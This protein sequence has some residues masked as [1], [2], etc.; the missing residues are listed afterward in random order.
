M[1]VY[2]V[3]SNG[4]NNAT[5][6]SDQPFRTIGQALNADLNPGDEIVVRAGTYNEALNIDQGGSA[7]GDITI[8]AEEPGTA[9]IRPP[10]GSWN[11]I[12]VNAN[13]VTIEGFDIA[14]AAGDGIEAN[15][16]HHITISDNIVH[17]NGESGIQFN[18]SEFI[19]VEGNETYDNAS[20]GW[21]SGISI[22]QNRN[23]SGD[24]T[25]PGY[26][27]IIRDN[28][29]HDNVTQSGAHT[30]GNGIIIDDFQSTQTDGY[31]NYTYPTLVE[32][33]IAYGNGGKGIQVTWSDYV[34]VSNN[35]AYHN[36]VDQQN[37][38]TWRGEISNA[39]SSNN[40]FINNIAV[41]D[42]SINSHNTAIDNNSY[43]GYT[44]DNVVWQDNVLYNGTDGKLSVS[45]DGGNA[46]PS[47]ADGNLIGVDPEFVD[48]EN[49]DFTIAAGSAAMD[50]GADADGASPL[51]TPPA[52]STPDPVVTPDPAPA[53]PATDNAAPIAQDDY[54]FQAA[55]SE[56]LILEKS[57]LLSNDRDADG[58]VLV[59]T[60][61][62]DSSKGTA[63]MTDQND[64]AFTPATSATGTASVTYTVSDQHGGSDTA[65]AYIDIAAQQPASRPATGTDTAS[66]DELHTVWSDSD[67]PD[68]A[69]ENDHNSVEL[70]MRF[71]VTS[72]GEIEGARVYRG[73]AN[74]SD[75]PATLW[76]GDG[77]KIA[78][79]TFS[80]TGHA[81]WQQ[82]DFDSPV[83]V[84]AGESYVISYHAP[85]G[86][87]AVSENYFDE[88]AAHGPI[89]T[90]A[91]AGV[92]AYG[93]QS[94]LPT[95]SYHESNYWVDVVFSDDDA[96]AAPATATPDPVVDS[97]PDPV[98]DPVAD[99]EVVAAP[100]APVDA[101]A[102]AD[103]STPAD[104][105]LHTVWS[106]S[107]TPDVSAENDHNSVELGMR[108]TVT[109][110]GEIEG[111]R[112][113]RG[114]A[115]DSDMP[116]TLWDGD[117]NK[118]AT[119]TFS[120][121]GHAGWQQID[122]DN[123]VQVSA[124]ESYVISYH[125]PE[126]QY[127]V[128]ENYFDESAAHGPIT[129][130][131]N[132]GVYAYGTQSKLPTQSY[133]ESNYWVDVVFDE[134]TAPASD[135][136]EFVFAPNAQSDSAANVDSAPQD[137]AASDATTPVWME[138]PQ[139]DPAPV[140]DLPFFDLG[141]HFDWSHWGGLAS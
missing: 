108:F 41:A 35:T 117:G 138:T 44:N 33:N 4:N 123:P 34:T 5:G 120:D 8:R 46:A 57:Q 95:Q 54:N 121:T 32:N 16:V 91:N 100:K 114:A 94:K 113:Y 106:D 127:A 99:P 96:A 37:D 136:D 135:A 82:V 109:S 7:A 12:S 61:I 18:Y 85:E 98:P 23:V 134:N 51:S 101:P 128:S 137:L 27:T 36:N 84:S 50:H 89:T 52:A 48:P 124:G 45:T 75:M 21:Y 111:A 119:A 58:D 63:V 6:S 130:E 47:A 112:V 42:P 110:D 71:T 17:G 78:T 15:S 59:L 2:Y 9:L 73:A 24:T 65:T 76:D 43:G 107:D 105:E 81:G 139:A 72:D 86:Q 67:T 88:S 39:Q 126:G 55:P 38:G 133:H 129:T 49:G 68:V 97:T 92:Y 62:V 60:N 77:N 132:A 115:N 28:I 103:T 26:R 31:P 69:A 3:D 70:G 116:A 22:Y 87:Y 125:A 64:I 66:S 25:T 131:A 29:T 13:Y 30:D 14:N 140:D 102:S 118:I 141:H 122:F 20:S 74:D 40:T 104:D 93:T 80:D 19:I 56:P 11:A 90:E 10:S 79:A 53:A 83:Q 1:T